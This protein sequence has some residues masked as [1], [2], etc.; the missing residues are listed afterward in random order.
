MCVCASVFPLCFSYKDDIQ[1]EHDNVNDDDDVDE[2]TQ[3][4]HTRHHTIDWLRR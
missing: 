3:K 2:K 4:L 1:D